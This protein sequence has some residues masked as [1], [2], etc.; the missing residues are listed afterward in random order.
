[1]A[2]QKDN[3]VEGN[4]GLDEEERDNTDVT[5]LDD[6][7]LEKGLTDADEDD[8]KGADDSGEEDEPDAEAEE[9][10]EEE[11]KEAAAPEDKGDNDDDD[12]LA[13]VKAD[14]ERLLLENEA[15]DRASVKDQEMI[16]R[17][18]NEIGGLRKGKPEEDDPDGEKFKERFDDNP[19]KAMQDEF[20]AER[21]RDADIRADNARLD[22]ETRES[23]LKDFPEFEA[24]KGEIVEL[25]KKDGLE[26]ENINLFLDHTW[27]S[28]ASL[29]KGYARQVV[30][31]RR[32]V[33]LEASG[34]KKK[35]ETKKALKRVKD[36]VGG[37]GKGL[38]GNIAPA[39][40][41]GKGEVAS[42]QISNMSNAELD[43]ALKSAEAAE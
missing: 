43:A 11:G 29:L 15:K 28:P 40:K 30:A 36:A 22:R 17:Q 6:A 20:A 26:Q 18:G 33:E 4:D 25:A 19:K 34:A 16:A 21:A 9:E 27:S 5:E 38:S 1:M 3:F 12:E 31:N 13:R 7:A 24:M 39:G 8:D 35:G 37:G 14:N 23:V 32:V 2:E 41:D 10:G 42:S